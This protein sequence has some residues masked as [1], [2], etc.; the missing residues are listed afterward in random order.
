VK[1]SDREGDQLLSFYY[2][3]TK[4]HLDWASFQNTFWEASAQRL[5]Q[6]LGAFG[7]LGLKKGIKTFLDHVPAGLRNLHLAA[8]KTTSLPRLEELAEEC[9]RMIE[10][11]KYFK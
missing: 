5:M 4:W 3:L 6:A 8:T 10:Q 7:F 9:L 1:L 11:R 2:G